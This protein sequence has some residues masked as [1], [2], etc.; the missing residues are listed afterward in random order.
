MSKVIRVQEDAI[1]IALKYGNSV[2]EG[3]RS[4]ENQL[5]K[6]KSGIDIEDIRVVIQEELENLRRY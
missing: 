2:S 1:E 6:Q 5:K 3:I 4:M